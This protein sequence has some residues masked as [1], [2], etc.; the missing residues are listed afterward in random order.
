[1]HHTD[2]RLRP[3]SEVKELLKPKGDSRM[4]YEKRQIQ[5]AKI[6]YDFQGDLSEMSPDFTNISR[7]LCL[8]INSLIDQ[9]VTLEGMECINFCE[10]CGEHTEKMD[11]EGVYLCET[12][13]KGE[14]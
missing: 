3:Y 5:K 11:C 10:S 12:C 7:G 9:V 1:M 6:L 8:A 2:L 13:A 14:V 4:C